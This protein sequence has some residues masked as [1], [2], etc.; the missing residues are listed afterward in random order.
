[1]MRG[2]WVLIAATLALSGCK[3][4][5]TAAEQAAA[6]AKAIAQVE[7]AQHSF[8]PPEPLDPQQITAADLQRAGLLDAGCSFHAS[9]QNDPVLVARPKRAV[10]K[11]GR[12]LTS[13][14]SDP[15]STQL[16]LGT[17]THYVGKAGALR[18]AKAADGGDLGSQQ[19][20]EWSAT[21]TVTDQHDRLVY[22][23]AGRLRCGA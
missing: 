5:P 4:Q 14:A 11:V 13:F 23:S 12:A 22:T 7:A 1:M 15:G 17:W 3:P 8:P 6:D 18:I 19:G 21:L 10:M 9:G 2:A 20:L 16:P